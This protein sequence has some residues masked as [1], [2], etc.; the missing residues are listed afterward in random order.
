MDQSRVW[1]RLL[2]ER[3]TRS[4]AAGQPTPLRRAIAHDL[5]VLLNTRTAIP[6]QEL[7]GFPHC[8]DSIVNFGLADFAHLC[9]ASSMDREEI[10]NRLASAIARHEPRLHG[11]QVRLSDAPDNI[12][13]LSLVIH[14][15][16]HGS[17]QDSMRFDITLQPS[18]L[19]YTIR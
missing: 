2:G 16:L 9:L 12:D 19:R 18:S 10:C 14:G 8:R 15:R 5:E 4:E 1:A 7:A 11:V 3:F 17:A 6:A 13:R